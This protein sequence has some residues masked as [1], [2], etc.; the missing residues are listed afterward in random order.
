MT[1]LKHGKKGCKGVLMV[2]ASA[3]ISLLTPSFSL[4]PSG[5]F[6]LGIVE[7]K[8]RQKAKFTDIFVCS[9]C[10]ASLSADSDEITAP[11]NVCRKDKPVSEMYVST[12]VAQICESCM[13]IL[14]DPSKITDDPKIQEYRQYVSL[15]EKL[16]TVPMTKI[17]KTK[18]SM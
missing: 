3:A 1:V 2:D 7:L 11:C 12:I 6:M 4:K 17:M 14:S 16:P 15:P 8:E 10:Y 13:E 5:E 18:F 9:S